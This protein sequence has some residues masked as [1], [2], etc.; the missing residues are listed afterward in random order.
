MDLKLTTETLGGIPVVT[1]TGELSFY[2]A[3]QFRTA[4]R[5]VTDAGHYRIVID[6]GGCDFLDSTGLGVIIGALKNA[7]AKSADGRIDIA[8]DTSRVLGVF[9][10]TGLEKVFAIHESAE[11]A[12]AAM[13]GLAAQR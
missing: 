13:T 12:V 2:T 4:L 8:C 5:D 7:R 1:V 10:I 6:L 3:G 11:D 9:R